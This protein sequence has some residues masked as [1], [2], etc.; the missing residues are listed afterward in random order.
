M[1]AAVPIRERVVCDDGDMLGTVWGVR[2]AETGLRFACDDFVKNPAVRAW[3]GTS[4]SVPAADLWPWVRQIRALPTPTIGST[5][6]DVA[7]HVICLA[8]RGHWHQPS[9]EPDRRHL[10]Q[11]TAPPPIGH[12]ADPE[13]RV[14]PRQ[15]AN[16]QLQLPHRRRAT[17]RANGANVFERRAGLGCHGAQLGACL[18]EACWLNRWMGPAIPTDPTGRS[19]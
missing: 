6:A 1:R 18:I 15:R 2:D 9:R 16:G 13:D 4:V 19:S 12:R 3:R 7:R 8:R 11:H 14:Q 5:S 10:R 17:S